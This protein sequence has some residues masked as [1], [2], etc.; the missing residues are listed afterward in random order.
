MGSYSKDPR[1]ERSR[2]A[3]L[4]AGIGLLLEGGLPAVTVEAIVERSGVARSTVYRHWGSRQEL[5]FDTFNRVMPPDT[6]VRLEGPLRERLRTLVESRVE[7]L[8][9]SPLGRALPALIAATAHDPELAPVRRRLAELHRRPLEQALEQAIV[10]GELPPHTDVSE[11]SAQLMGPLFFR[12]LITLEPI[13]RSFAHRLVDLFLASRG[14]VNTEPTDDL[15][16]A[17]PE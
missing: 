2:E 4:E 13:D 11:A 16:S 17:P 14:A 10:D 5:I 3:V 6:G 8:Q 7:R 9:R 1:V 12:Q 15:A